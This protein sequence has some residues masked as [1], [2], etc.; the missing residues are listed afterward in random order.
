MPRRAEAARGHAGRSTR[1]HACNTAYGRLRPCIP[2]LKEGDGGG[3]LF[4]HDRNCDRTMLADDP[5]AEPAY[6]V[7]MVIKTDEG[8]VTN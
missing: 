6:R 1:L 5:W 3:T 4:D 2:R 8:S 7:D